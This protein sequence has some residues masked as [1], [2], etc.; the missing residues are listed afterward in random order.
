[1]IKR[2][3]VLS[4][5]ML[6][7]L[8][9]STAMQFQSDT[10]M[11][12][13]RH[14]I[15]TEDWYA[16][17]ELLSFYGSALQ[18]VWIAASKAYCWGVIGQ[19]LNLLADQGE[20]KG[21]I[22]DDLRIIGNDINVAADVSGS[23]IF[24]GSQLLLQKECQINKDALIW[25]SQVEISGT[26]SGSITVNAT[27]V[28]ING[29]IKNNA[30][31]K[32]QSIEFGP[33]SLIQGHL[34]YAAPSR[35]D[36]SDTRHV[37]GT[38]KWSKSPTSSQEYSWPFRVDKWWAAGKLFLRVTLFVGLLILGVLFILF[39]P[40]RT[41][42][43]TRAISKLPLPSLG[44]GL[45]IMIG[46]PL[47]VMLLVITIIGIPLALVLAVAYIILYG[48]SKLGMA[49][50]LGSFLLRPKTNQ[51][52]KYIVAL[53][54]GLVL[55]TAAEMVPYLGGLLGFILALFGTGGLWV[56][57]TDKQKLLLKRVGQ[58]E[59]GQS[60][61]LA[62]ATAGNNQAEKPA[63]QGTPPEDWAQRPPAFLNMASATG[64][65]KKKGPAKKIRKKAQSGPA[66][67]AAS[68]SSRTAKKVLSKKSSTKK[69]I[70]KVKK[71]P[72]K[73]K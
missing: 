52:F 38:I 55:V 57:I 11:V 43:Y 40:E 30:T 45:L 53:V 9:A 50:W 67:K 24:L 25:A 66:K 72:S 15:I 17:S 73:K 39:R 16:A 1:M 36:Q 70:K 8:T 54:L 46:I 61:T 7:W 47:I 3:G 2:I 10:K 60:E 56:M 32:A 63:P 21:E 34:N 28:I 14:D 20:I 18:D 65:S 44:W 6:L 22:G 64:Q 69:I 13:E 4:A 35:L 68:Q 5:G 26:L 27:K 49:L 62:T 23:L 42:H 19:D 31:I 29:T 33:Q 59:Q 58:I 51:G 71:Q 37:K 12:V 41:H 48:L